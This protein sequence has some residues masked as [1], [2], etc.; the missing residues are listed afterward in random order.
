MYECVGEK[1]TCAEVSSVSL[2]LLLC[3]FG[4]SALL[5]AEVSGNVQQPMVDPK[6]DRDSEWRK[7]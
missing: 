5:C 2:L 3:S 7:E 6:N 1:H 4:R